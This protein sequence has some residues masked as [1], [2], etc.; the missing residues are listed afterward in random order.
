MFVVRQLCLRRWLFMNCLFAIVVAAALT[1]PAFSQQPKPKPATSGQ[2]HTIVL[3]S[4]G[5]SFA[6]EGPKDWIAD[7]KVGRRLG[8]CCVYYPKGSWDTAETVMYPNIVTKGP[9]KATLQ[10][11][12][13]SDLAK[14]R[15]DNPGM[16]YV[17]G[18]MPFK[19]RTAKV[20]YFH[21]VNQGSSEAVAY[22]DEEKIMALVVL[23]SKTEKGLTDALPLLLG[24]LETYRSGVTAMNAK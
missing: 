8:V 24:V 15:K 6:I 21:G 22:I 10:E 7:R 9:G 4:D 13:D 19:N 20:R 1:L 12:M 5:G 11:L 23:S 14:F 18:D 16:T 2:G 17:D 3:E